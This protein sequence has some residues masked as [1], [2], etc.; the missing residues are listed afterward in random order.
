MDFVKIK[1]AERQRAERLVQS[2]AGATL[3]TDLQEEA[4][5]R[6][7]NT[8]VPGEG[9]EEDHRSFTATTT[10]TAEQKGLIRTMLLEASSAKEVEDIENAVRRGV[11]PKMLKKAASAE[12][13]EFTESNSN[14]DTVLAGTK[15]TRES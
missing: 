8:F 4:A 3:E 12:G 1:P 11:L 10:F 9:L 15:R 13:A 14:G 2:A 5:A 7:S 6:R